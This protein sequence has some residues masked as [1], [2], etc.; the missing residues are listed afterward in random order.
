MNEIKMSVARK[1]GDKRVAVGDVSIFIP[2]L[3][4][5]GLATEQAVDEAGAPAVS[6]GLPVYKS[7]AANWLQEAIAAAVK[8]QARNRLISG[9]TTLKPGAA[10]STTLEQLVAETERVGGG[11]ALKTIRDCKVDFAAWVAGLGKSASTQDTLNVMFANKSSLRLQPQ[12]HKDKMVDY[13]SQFAESLDA[14]KLARYSRYLESVQ[15]AAQAV[16]EIASDF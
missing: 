6:D 8:A 9:S 7:Q 4:E 16:I 12:G 15:D 5:F 11:E 10:I 3:S 1:D 14:D 13:V 2:T